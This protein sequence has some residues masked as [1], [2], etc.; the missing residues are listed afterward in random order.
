LMLNPDEAYQHISRHPSGQISTKSAIVSSPILYWEHPL[1][2]WKH[3][4]NL[5]HHG[6][7]I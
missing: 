7:Q 5:R 6:V 3:C 4:G 1:C 2:T